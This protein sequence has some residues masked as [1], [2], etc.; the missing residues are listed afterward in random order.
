MTDRDFV[1]TA[2][3][4]AIERDNKFSVEAAVANV[5]TPRPRADDLRDQVL[6]VVDQQELSTT[7]R[8]FAYGYVR[9]DTDVVFR[10]IDK[11]GRLHLIVAITGDEIDEVAFWEIDG[12]LVEPSSQTNSNGN[13]T[14]G[15]YKGLARLKERLGKPG[16]GV[17]STLRHE[18]S[19][20]SNFRGTGIAYLYGRFKFKDGV[21]SGDPKIR[22]IVKARKPI[23]PRDGVQRWTINPLV[24]AYDALI[25]SKQAGGAGRPADQIDLPSWQAAA[26]FGEG[27]VDAK[28][29]SKLTRVKSHAVDQLVFTDQPVNDF[30]WGDVVQLLEKDGNGLPSGL[31]ADTDYHVIPRRHRA[32]DIGETGFPSLRLASSFANAMAGQFLSFTVHADFF[33][34][35]VKEV[36]YAAAGSY[37]GR[38]TRDTLEKI[39]A[40]A[41]AKLTLKGG[42]IAVVTQ[43]YP[44]TIKTVTT[45]DIEGN[46]TLSNKV[47]LRERTTSLTGT[48]ISP[49]RLFQPDDYPKVGGE[50]FEAQ[51]KGAFP[52]RFDLEFVPK[53]STAQRLALAEFNQRRQEKR[54]TCAAKMQRY[55]IEAGDVFTIDYP[56]LGLD[57]ETPFQCTSRRVFA[58]I[59]GGIPRFRLDFTARQL[60][61]N[62]FDPDIS[63]EQLILASK[64]P[65]NADPRV[66]QPPST[67]QISEA[68]FSTIEGGWRSGRGHHGVGDIGRSV[69]SDLS[70]TI[71]A[72]QRCRV[73]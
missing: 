43:E 2:E 65:V 56:R 24:M 66:V 47:G 54:L 59:Q 10:E 42:K 22:V 40:A 63:A 52:Q 19:V 70:A 20:D 29:F 7:P 16:Q 45:A 26:S 39:L 46:I 36:R 58:E 3:A 18:T 9:L 68:Q 31:A 48:F 17:L 72:E 60:E 61:A 62:T 73:H 32:G 71:Q 44:S 50:A 37:R 4:L 13:V 23:D 53:A 25:K 27:L 34:K 57:A 8:Q 41:G 67:P 49:A 33:V 30:Q 5:E 69:L 55:D 12:I 11:K 6:T 1:T 51:D 28:A 64:L 35:K 15:R 21:F 14:S 38:F